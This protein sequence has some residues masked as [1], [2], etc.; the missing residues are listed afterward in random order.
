MRGIK[1]FSNRKNS[2][3][4]NEE[5]GKITSKIAVLPF[6]RKFINKQQH[7][8]VTRI[9]KKYRGCVI[10][11][12][13]IGTKVF[14]KAKIKLY[15]DVN[16]EIRAKRRHKQLIEQGE[17][18]IYSQILKDLKLRDKTDRT[19]KESPLAIP[20][21]AIIIDNSKTFKSTINQINKALKNL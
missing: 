11:G 20:A 17:K 14:K 10:D 7:S 3:L 21:K 19:R 18:S 4:R 2:N 1:N 15:I 6:I 12:R 16:I 5:V 9:S 13:D 8:I